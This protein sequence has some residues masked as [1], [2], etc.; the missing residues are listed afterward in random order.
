MKKKRNFKATPM[1]DYEKQKIDVMPSDK[2]LTQA[3]RPIF[4]SDMLPKK[5]EK[6]IEDKKSDSLPDFLF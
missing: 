6:V 3:C 1:P 4:Y 5:T 2:P